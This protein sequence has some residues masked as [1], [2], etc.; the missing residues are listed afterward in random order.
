M[1]SVRHI[2]AKEVRVN[3]DCVYVELIV[4]DSLRVLPFDIVFDHQFS[5]AF[6]G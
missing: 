6:K 3:P 5:S 4:N 1:S 2:V